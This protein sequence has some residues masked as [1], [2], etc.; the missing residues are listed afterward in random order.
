MS[1]NRFLRTIIENLDKCRIPHMV[2][3][4]M[5]STHH[6][7]PRTTQD[8]DIVIDANIDSVRRFV[9]SLPTEQFYVSEEAALDAVHRRSMFNVIDMASGWKADLIIRRD[10][11]FSRTEFLRRQPATMLGVD[12]F[13]ATAEDT[14]LAKL[15][16]AK[17]SLSEH[18]LNDVA[19]VI[20]VVG[21]DLDTSYI[22]QWVERLGIGHLWQSVRGE[23]PTD[24]P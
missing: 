14:I 1:L 16:W 11:D 3:G 5:A 20:D 13:V 21:D 12:V 8:V 6:G 19:A 23:Y 2:A 22:E 18:Q 9:G 10:R 24:E 17:S 7:R 15:E 4:S